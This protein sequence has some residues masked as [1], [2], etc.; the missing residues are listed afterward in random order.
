MIQRAA[1]NLHLAM[2]AGQEVINEAFSQVCEGGEEGEAPCVHPNPVP[3]L[4]AVR[5][6]IPPPPPP[7]P[8]PQGPCDRDCSAAVVASRAPL[9]RHA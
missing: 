3:A 2:I 6:P 7:R 8:A 9:L 1:Y 4:E 5:P